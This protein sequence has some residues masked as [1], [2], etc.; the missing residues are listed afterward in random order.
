M[1]RLAGRQ[2]TAVAAEL[3]SFETMSRFE[4]DPG[5]VGLANQTTEHRALQPVPYLVHGSALISRV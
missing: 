3:D 5:L 2:A 4:R 1:A